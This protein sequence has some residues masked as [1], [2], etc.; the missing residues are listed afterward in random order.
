M[1]A[2]FDPNATPKESPGLPSTAD[3]TPTNNS[4]NEVPIAIM[5]A[6]S[7]TIPLFR[8]NFRSDTTVISAALISTMENMTI[9]INSKNDIV[10]KLLYC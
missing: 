8:T 7:P 10:Y 1:F 2:I 9:N 6:E 4:G 3:V 5:T